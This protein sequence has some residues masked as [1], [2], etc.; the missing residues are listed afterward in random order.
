VTNLVTTPKVSSQDID[1]VCDLVDELCGICW[2]ES[3]AYLIEA[4]LQTLVEQQGC[5]NYQALVH[6]VRKEVASGLKEEFVDA[7]TTNETLWFRDKSPFEAIQFKLLPELIDDKAKGGFSKRLRIWSAACSTG[8]E[9]YSIAMTLAETIPDIK[10][11]D[12]KILGT[13]ISRAAV[14]Q[15]EQATYGNLEMS[16]GM[17]PTFLRKYFVQQGDH[18][19]V[20]DTIRSMCAFKQRNLL[21]PFKG[22]GPFDMIFCRNVAIYFDEPSRASLFERAAE[23][24]APN[25]WL[26][27]GSS[28]S[29][30]DLGPRW[31]PQQHCR[32]NC[33][34][35]N[36]ERV[37][38]I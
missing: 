25:G 13:D 36:M 21:E 2:D 9:A 24:L 8:Q 33:Y 3:K 17:N 34:R 4:R 1:S 29:L 30:I 28:E 19:Q 23:V 22:L 35:P 15:T 18:W 12:I 10:S 31:K 14:E 6:K 7:V 20:N 11:W 5:E 16:R 37:Q 32:S 27:V 26:F 38:Y